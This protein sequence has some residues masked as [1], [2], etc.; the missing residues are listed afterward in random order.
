MT[1]LVMALPPRALVPL[2]LDARGRAGSG[3]S[4]LSSG[5]RAGRSRKIGGL[6]FH[7]PRRFP[8]ARIVYTRREIWRIRRPRPYVRR[9]FGMAAARRAI[10]HGGRRVVEQQHLPG[11]GGSR[12]RR[13]RRR[14]AE[15]LAVRE[16]AQVK[17]FSAVPPAVCEREGSYR[18]RQC[19]ERR[20]P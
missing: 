11:G 20:R 7:V 16:V 9:P 6:Q 1:P 3:P 8:I 19:L 12:T 14:F 5:A 10:E 17:A 15:H 4:R 13:Y 2:D 18:D